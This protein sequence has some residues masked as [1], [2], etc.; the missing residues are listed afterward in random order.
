MSWFDQVPQFLL[1]LVLLFIPGL[2]VAV[3]ARLEGLRIFALAP[4]ISVSIV[5]ISAVAAPF[6]GLSWSLLP[7]LGTTAVM[8]GLALAASFLVAR[9][10]NKVGARHSGR[11]QWSVLAVSAVSVILAA[12]LVSR[13]L[14]KAIGQPES[15]SQT[16][17]NVFHL[18]AI[19]YIL[20]TGSG[21]SLTL[22][23][24]TGASSYPAA[25]H[26]LVSLLVSVGGGGIPASVNVVNIV[27]AALVWPLGCI[28]LAQAIWGNRPAIC[29]SAGVL[30]AAFGAFPISLLD[31]GVLYPNFLAVA[32]LPLVVGISVEVLGLS[33]APIRSRFIGVLVLLAV[34]PGLSLAHPSAAMAW[35][36]M[37]TPA[38]AYVYVRLVARTL[39]SSRG[40]RRALNLAALVAVLVGTVMVVRLL[41]NL[42]RPPAEAAFW[43]PVETTG[44]AIGEVIASSAI[45][46]PV[47]WA[48]L[49]LT[50]IGIY[51]TIRSRRQLWWLGTY[52]VVGF[53]FVVVSS[54]PADQFRMYW[55]GIWYND[56][57][58]LAALLPLVTIPLASRGAV[59]IWDLFFKSSV[60]GMEALQ[61]KRLARPEGAATDRAAVRQVATYSTVAGLLMVLALGAATQRANVR[62]AQDAMA[63]SYRLAADSPL[64]SQDELKLIDRLPNEVPKDAVLV[65]NP[66]NG[67]SLAYALADRK[68][69]QLHILSA[70]PEGTA[71]LLNGPTPAKD[72]PATCPAVRK[73]NIDYILDFGHREVHGRDNGYKGLD[74]LIASGLATLEDSEGEAKLY[75][76]HLCDS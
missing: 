67:S 23:A 30:S 41:W 2:A 21:S 27:V 3:A 75:K 10:S 1:A 62:Q 32:L 47:G 7:V 6:L 50:L 61:R 44:Q 31:F 22:N 13:R 8:T 12:V 60:R 39:A 56:P 49:A 25:W 14:I 40:R 15:F 51:V 46:R 43:P 59:C 26:D 68:L 5:A 33:P 53:L 72:D 34:L 45:G 37:M 58:R 38:A 73:L 64:V 42:V 28:Y 36:A 11:P 48:V 18:N 4:G 16:F 69:I 71:A 63:G 9:K 24:M 76:L 54:F 74:N 70:V 17:D 35:I 57:P 52:A 55:T 20:D 19:R 66:W 65:G 29:I